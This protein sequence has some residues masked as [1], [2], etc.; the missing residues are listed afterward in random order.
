[1]PVSIKKI[2]ACI[3]LS[4]AAWS[5]LPAQSMPLT[6]T[7]NNVRVKGLHMK[8]EDYYI[9]VRAVDQQWNDTDFWFYSDSRMY[10]KGCPREYYLT[11]VTKFRL[12]QFAQ[13][14]DLPVSV[15][16]SKGYDEYPGPTPNKNIRRMV[17][18]PSGQAIDVVPNVLPVTKTIE[19]GHVVGVGDDAVYIKDDSSG[20]TYIM[21]HGGCELSNSEVRAWRQFVE[22]ELVALKQD[23]PVKA[24][25]DYRMLELDLLSQ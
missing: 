23:R 18:T 10:S 14:N 4:F 12:L 25:F 6:F 9:S 16:L 22:M 3:G 20:L 7:L 17:V 15:D 11:D 13:I 1:M 24:K 21:H 5:A 19:R 8:G 2:L